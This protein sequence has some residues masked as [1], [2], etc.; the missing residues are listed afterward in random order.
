[1]SYPGLLQPFLIPTRAW[2]HVAMDFISGLPKSQGKD[3][4][5]VVI[6]RY[7]KYSYFFALTYPYTAS[8]IAQV[9]IDNVC[10]LH[11]LPTSIVSYR[12]PISIS[13]FW[14]ELFKG[15]K[16]QLKPSLAYHPQTDEQSERLNR[17]LETYLR[18]MIG[19]KP[20]DWSKWLAQAEFNSNFHSSL[21]MSPFKAL[22]SYE[23]PMPTFE[24]V[25]QIKV[26]FVDHL[27]RERQLMD[28]MLKDNL[29]RA[30]NRM[31]HFADNRRSERKFEVGDWVFLKLQ[32]Y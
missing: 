23:S 15:L 19:H 20:T 8:Q 7:T 3:S 4:V 11:G 12:D 24:L 30:Q 9:F 17:C 13:T 22:Y 5:L 31:K 29:I 10:K 14:R 32:P 2:E 25:A 28:K 26:D 16:V 21:G 6:N 27:L 1:M 18:Y